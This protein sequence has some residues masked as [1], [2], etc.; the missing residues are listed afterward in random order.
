MEI[1]FLFWIGFAL[2]YHEINAIA[3]ENFAFFRIQLTEPLA[4]AIMKQIIETEELL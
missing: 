4:F 3:R 2:F 1:P